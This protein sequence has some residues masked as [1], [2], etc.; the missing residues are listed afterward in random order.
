M[1][2]KSF[3]DLLQGFSA[4]RKPNPECLGNHTIQIGRTPNTHTHTLYRLD[5]IVSEMA[6]YESD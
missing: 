2:T 3:Q 6:G 1:T 5:E 4:L